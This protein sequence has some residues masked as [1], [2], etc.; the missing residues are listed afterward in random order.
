[1][2]SSTTASC[3]DMGPGPSSLAPCRGPAPQCRSEGGPR[4]VPICAQHLIG[5]RLQTGMLEELRHPLWAE[6]QESLRYQGHQCSHFLSL[7]GKSCP[8][9]PCCTS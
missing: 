6:V 9:D 2:A 7:R 4:S 8:P 3:R 5:R 1:M